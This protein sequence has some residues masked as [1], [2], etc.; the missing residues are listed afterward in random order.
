MQERIDKAV[1]KL[2]ELEDAASKTDSMAKA[3]ARKYIVAQSLADSAFELSNTYFWEEDAQKQLDVDAKKQR[4]AAAETKK[5]ATDLMAVSKAALEAFTKER[6]R[7]TAVAK[8]AAAALIRD[9]SRQAGTSELESA[10]EE[11]MK[12]L[13]SLKPKSKSTKANAD[14]KGCVFSHARHHCTTTKK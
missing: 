8:A 14:K 12:P 11:D 4:D 7:Q 9:R 10:D 13:S 6:H 3:A 5:E 2:K 1:E